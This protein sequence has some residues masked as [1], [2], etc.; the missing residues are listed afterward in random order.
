M[1]WSYIWYIHIYLWNIQHSC[2]HPLNIW[3]KRTIFRVYIWMRST[4]RQVFDGFIGLHRFE[5]YF[6]FTSKIVY[7]YTLY[8]YEY[9]GIYRYR[10]SYSIFGHGLGINL[11]ASKRSPP[12]MR[13]KHLVLHAYWNTL[14]HTR[15]GY[16]FF[17]FFL[18]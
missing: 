2:C 3:C 6:H 16:K 14:Q 15:I 8:K 9:I 11:S 18:G 1:K 5:F 13:G 12:T 7:T 17:Y 10:F 4:T